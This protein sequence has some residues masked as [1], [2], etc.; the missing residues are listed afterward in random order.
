MLG[1][2]Q[3]AYCFFGQSSDSKQTLNWADKLT[4]HRVRTELRIC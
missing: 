2:T 4:A 3:M 1:E